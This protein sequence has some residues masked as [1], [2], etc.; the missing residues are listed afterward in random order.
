MSGTFDVLP[1]RRDRITIETIHAAFALS[2]VLHLLALFGW[3][4]KLPTLPFDD[5]KLGRKSGSL[6]VRLMPLPQTAP[7]PPPAPAREAVMESSAH[8]PHMPRMA[9]LPP[10]APVL[11]RAGPA[12]AAMPAPAAAQSP[13][14]EQDFAAAVEARRRARAQ[15]E[16]AAAPSPPAETEQERHNREVAANL[17]LNTTPNFGSE[18]QRGGG[19][20][21]IERIG[22]DD[23]EFFF[24]G[25][26][27]DIRRNAQQMIEVRKGSNP[28]MQIA[29]VRK[30]IEIIRQH[31]KGDFVWESIR[32]NRDVTLSA[33]QEDNAGLEDFLMKEFFSDPRR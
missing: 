15:P 23:A 25:W 29:V 32:L 18:R 22:Y 30:M 5:D 4:P 19:M 2:I 11:A 13:S 26:N 16:S 14:A 7:T 8:R 6:A 27:K 9:H 21:Q 3:L 1:S 17:G 10:S 24:Y 20:F 31:V 28:N 33:A 12:P